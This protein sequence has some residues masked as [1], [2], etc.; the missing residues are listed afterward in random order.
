MRSLPAGLAAGILVLL[1]CLCG[2]TAPPILPPATTP[3]PTT[4]P[5]TQ[6]QTPVPTTIAPPDTLAGTTWYLIAFNQAGSSKS[7]LPG[8]EITALFDDKGT[9]AGSA[10]CNQYTATYQTTLSGLSI[11]SPI[12][13][14]MSC[15][16]PAGIMT[17]ESAYLTTIQGASTYSIV[18]SILTIMDSNGRAILT[19]AKAPP[20]VM[21]PSP[22]VGTTWYLTSIVEGRGTIWSPTAGSPISVL[23]SNDGKVSGDAGCNQ[24]T[25]SYSLS[26]NS[27]A[28]S[29]NFAT[30]AMFCAEPGVMDIEQTYLAVLPQMTLYQITGSQLTLSDGAGKITMLYTVNPL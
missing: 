11:K 8:T 22:M 29:P 30:T 6:A 25:G 7:I 17:Q 3:P 26:G 4:A 9:V 24:Y 10:G 21:T 16:S 18:N 20:N 5:V 15:S 1:L 23:F 19:Y 28:I 14:K 12:S 27:L 2:C 13:T